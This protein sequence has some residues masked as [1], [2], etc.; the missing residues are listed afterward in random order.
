MVRF[1]I[2]ASHTEARVEGSLVTGGMIVLP[3]RPHCT[4]LLCFTFPF[5]VTKGTQMPRPGLR[6]LAWPGP[7]RLAFAPNPPLPL[8]QRLRTHPAMVGKSARALTATKSFSTS[9]VQSSSNKVPVSALK[10]KTCLTCGRMITPRAKWAKDWDGIKYCSDRC[11]STR[12]GKVV[13]TFRASA[14]SMQVLT[15]YPGA[16]CHAG[17]VRVDIETFVEGALLVVAKQPGGGLLEDAQ[18]RIRDLLVSAPIPTGADDQTRTRSNTDDDQDA[19]PTLAG[20]DNGSHLDILWKAL[21]SPPGFRERIRRAARRLSLGITHESALHQT[22]VT[23]TQA[24][25]IELLQSGK[26]L[27]TVQDL[28]F[29]KGVIHLEIKKRRPN[30]SQIP[31]QDRE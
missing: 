7:R 31:D 6:N 11:R 13:A 23:T 14:Y 5:R 18:N 30:Q 16:E 12:P 24:G 1:V 15:Q 4:T 28:S 22:Y 8:A 27:R 19:Q 26:T 2:R 17:V 9:D 21:D 20:N 25:S 10:P 29:A 3:F